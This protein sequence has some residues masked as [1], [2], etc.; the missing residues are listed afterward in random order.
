VQIAL[1]VLLLLARFGQVLLGF[2]EVL[3]KTTLLAFQIFDLLAVLRIRRR[4]AGASKE[5]DA[6]KS[7]EKSRDLHYRIKSFL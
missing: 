4:N 6:D 3:L 7:E 1:A 2:L 5:E